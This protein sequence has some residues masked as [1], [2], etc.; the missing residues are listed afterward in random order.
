MVVA[1]NSGYE[2]GVMAMVV[3]ERERESD[4]TR[5]KG[6]MAWVIVILIN[7]H[8]EFKLFDQYPFAILFWLGNQ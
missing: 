8:L 1:A 3:Q 7:T 6:D 2:Q 4:Q 5:R